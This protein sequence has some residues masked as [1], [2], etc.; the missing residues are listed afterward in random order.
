MRVLFLGTTVSPYILIRFKNNKDY[1]YEG[2]EYGEML[3]IQKNF[4]RKP[5]ELLRYLKSK[6]YISYKKVEINI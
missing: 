1:K 6:K 4:K 2:F 5:G 3:I